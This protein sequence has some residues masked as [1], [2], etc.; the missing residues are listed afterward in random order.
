MPA[1]RP[2]IRVKLFNGTVLKFPAGTQRAVIDRVAKEQTAKI[3]STPTSGGGPLAQGLYGFN[4]ALTDVVHAP[5]ELAES[6]VQPAV[7]F[8]KSIMGPGP[9]GGAE[10]VEGMLGDFER[11]NL[12][13][14]E[15]VTQPE[16][17]A[18]RIGEEFGY[19]AP[20]AGA[21]LGVAPAV[22]AMAPARSTI[23]AGLQNLFKMI[24]NSPA[25]ATLG[26][27]ASVAGAGT[28][29]AIAGEFAPGDQDAETLGQ[30]AGGLAPAGLALAP[31]NLL[32]RFVGKPL[33]NRLLPSAIRT[34]SRK[35]A[36]NLLRR[37]MGPDAIEQ[38]KRGQEV[39]RAVGANFTVPEK[40][41]SPALLATQRAV[42]DEASGP[43]LDAH[44]RRHRANQAAIERFNQAQRPAGPEFS[45]VVDTATTKVTNILTNFGATQETL[46]ASVPHADLP[47]V[48]G[49]LR[50]RLNDLRRGVSEQFKQRAAELGIADQDVT[51]QFA[52]W[53]PT[54]SGGP[55][56]PFADAA[57][58]PKIEGEIRGRLA[59]IRAAMESGDPE[60]LARVRLTY[61]D[62]KRMRERVS[63]DLIDAL[64]SANPASKLIRSLTGMKNGIDTFLDELPFGDDYRQFRKDYL[65]QY[66]ERF[67]NASAMKIRQR[68]NRAFYQ[69]ADESVANAFFKSDSAADAQR[70]AQQFR[71]IYGD[72][73]A[74]V[75]NLQAAVLDDYRTSVMR[76]GKIDP[77]LAENWMRQ[78]ESVLREFPN[79]NVTPATLTARSRE[80]AERVKQIESQS[81]TRVLQS[82]DRGAQTSDDVLKSLIR[83]P[84][85][86]Q[87]FLS[88]NHNN[89][90]AVAGLRRALWDVGAASDNLDTFLNNPGIK[91]AFSA[92]HRKN[93]RTL[94]EARM[95]AQLVEEPGGQ[96]LRPNPSEGFEKI[97][98]MGIP[99]LA[100]RIFAVQSGRTGYNF[101]MTEILSR[102]LRGYS[103]KQAVT[104]LNEAMYN[105]EVARDLAAFAGVRA[106]SKA[107]TNRLNSWL[108]TLG[109]DA[110]TQEDQPRR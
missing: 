57:N 92:E 11:E 93:L 15:P 20:F 12:Y 8:V 60:A 101:V 94:F 82:Y 13:P 102:A 83:D 89:E 36:A 16:R 100:S 56:L 105:P 81:L 19:N 42:E 95:M 90:E 96:P 6:A 71:Q 87:Q 25:R 58:R 38:L 64:S 108:F 50:T 29:A 49:N 97:L 61:A 70:A 31:G 84:R 43:V 66:I 33:L 3:K 86:M 106:P 98:H 76:D 48:G 55:R 10:R 40:T 99:Q 78:H 23:G 62:M 28:G 51:P 110:N 72:D 2:S 35:V 45:A 4:K 22:A 91:L 9:S 32:M 103:E 80:L 30:L 52:E 104:L 68:D 79:L 67:E 39:E 74:A 54:I 77:R 107:G 34:N 27:A 44:V 5:A 24:G 47:A 46:G 17:I 85:K 37:E 21:M 7:D 53:A 69:T 88:R 73:P 109:V 1:P 65:T 59:Q 26:E 18:N 14:Q 63:D 41:G 75:S